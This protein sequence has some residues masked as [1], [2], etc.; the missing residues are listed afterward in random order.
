MSALE[1]GRNLLASVLAL[2]NA[3]LSS[4][5]ELFSIQIE[6]S[7]SRFLG[8]HSNHLISSRS[9]SASPSSTAH[10]VALSVRWSWQMSIPRRCISCTPLPLPF[11]TKRHRLQLPPLTS[12]HPQGN[13]QRRGSNLHTPPINT[14]RNGSRVSS[15]NKQIDRV[16]RERE[17]RDQFTPRNKQEDGDDSD[18]AVEHPA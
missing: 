16:Y 1:R 18:Q 8:S 7:S 6:V 15:R 12:P 2:R 13:H 14:R 5:R 11:P 17:V 4:F 3:V 9:I 10:R